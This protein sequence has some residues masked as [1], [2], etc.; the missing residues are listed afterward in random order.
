MHW[1][2]DVDGCLWC[3]VLDLMSDLTRAQETADQLNTQERMYGWGCTKY[4]NITK[5]IQ[6]LE[7]YHMLWM[8]V[9][10]FYDK[11][12]VWLNCPFKDVDAEEVEE[13][14]NDMFRK[15]FKLSKQF[16][17]VSGMLEKEAPHRVASDVRIKFVNTMTD[18]MCTW[19]E[20]IIQQVVCAV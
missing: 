19:D 2:A 8:T 7:P 4:G 12:S 14:V 3:Q 10:E 5:L 6:Q 17:G 20:F 18:R 16:S 15:V 13:I 11:S 9:F 1:H